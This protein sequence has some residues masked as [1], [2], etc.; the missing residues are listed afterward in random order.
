MP[1]KEKL[2]KVVKDKKISKNV[3]YIENANYNVLVERK[4]P[5]SSYDGISNPLARLGIDTPNIINAHEYKNEY[6]TARYQLLNTLYRDNWVVQ[7]IIAAVPDS[8][9]KKWFKVHT[10]LPQEEIN[11]L[12]NLYRKTKLISRVNEGMRW[13]R[14]Y[15]GAI[16]IILIKGQ[17]DNL[18]EPLDM[19]LIGPDCFLGLHI[20]DRWMGAYPSLE[21]VSDPEDRDF[22]LPEYYEIT[23][24]R[25]N[26]SLKVHHTKVIRFIGRELP[27]YERIRELYWGASEIESVYREIVRRDT[28][29]ENISSLI[30]KANLSVLKVKDLDQ[31]FSLSNTKAQ[32][33]FW[34]L[35]SSVSTLESSMGVKVIDS[36]S[37]AEYLNYTFSG[38]KEIYETIM[39]DLAGACRIPVTKLFGR[40]P[41]GMNATGESDLQNYYDYVDEV[42]ENQFRDIVMKLLPIM[43]ISCW[44]YIPDDLD[45]EFEEMKTLDELQKSTIA[46]QKAATIIEAYNTNL[47]PR[48]IAQKELQTLNDRLGIFGNITNKI[49]EE[50]KGLY[51]VD[52][53]T[54]RDPMGG[55]S[56]NNMFGEDGG[57]NSNIE[58]EHYDENNQDNTFNPRLGKTSINHNN[59]DN[60]H[61]TDDSLYG[62]NDREVNNPRLNIEN[63]EIDIMLNKI[64][65]DILNTSSK[66]PDYIL[67]D[68]LLSGNKLGEEK[69]VLFLELDDIEKLIKSKH[70]DYIGVLEN[71]ASYNNSDEVPLSVTE[72]LNELKTSYYN[73]IGYKKSIE[74]K[75]KENGYEIDLLKRTGQYDEQIKSLENAVNK[76][77][78]F[79]TTVKDSKPELL[80]LVDRLLNINLKLN[81]LYNNKKIKPKQS[82]DYEMIINKVREYDKNK[83]LDDELNNIENKINNIKGEL[84]L[85]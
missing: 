70:K 36:E 11:K 21:I 9:T 24:P 47:I 58:S 51:A 7:N 54:M 68:D 33:R 60:Q 52:I 66:K 28:T 19:D 38:V 25:L 35:M 16:G 34:N 45:F 57:F 41:A 62:G 39:M 69:D 59:I 14:L 40:S 74:N 44:G 18:D 85:C 79:L 50:S 73:L 65:N 53:M 30:F 49:I 6:I 81:N 48:D 31:L 22:G 55:L 12:N 29:A 42:R 80:S 3:K 84:K 26:I 43:A 27:N 8:I 2:S 15:G 64:K 76:L 20:I 1:K 37:S 56:Y 78:E 63:D 61:T 13:G 17:T 71:I 77:K 46:Q 10:S 72:K 5:T 75:L 67:K 82:I 23:D 83:I 32:E 4:E